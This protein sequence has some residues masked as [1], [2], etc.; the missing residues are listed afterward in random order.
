MGCARSL[1][2]LALPTL[3]LLAILA[4][5][6]CAA[7]VT[8]GTILGTVTDPSGA[9]LPGVV[10]KITNLDQGQERQTKTNELGDYLF[11]SL[12]L[13]S[14]RLSAEAKAFQTSVREGLQLHV[15]D[16]IRIDISMSVGNM[17]EKVT[18]TE[19]A[20]L[21]RSEDATQAH[22]INN[23]SILEMPLNNRNFAALALTAPGVH[24]GVTG[25]TLG[26][27]LG[28]GVSIW[29]NGQREFNNA[30]NL[31]GANMNIGFYSWNSFNP[32]VDAVQEFTI[33]S[34]L[35]SAEFGFQSG[36]NI[37][38]A[39][40]SGSNQLHGTLYDFLQNDD[41]N[42]RNFF[43]T[44][45]PKLRQ[46]QF[47]GTVGGPVYLPKLYNGR[48]RT[49]FFFNYEGVRTRQSAIQ[50]QT[51]P[52]SAQRG[53]DLSQTQ[54]G[55]AFTG[56]ILDPLNKQP[57]PN[58]RIPASRISSQAPKIL[59][60]Y[61]M[62]NT[63]G[64]PSYNFYALGPQPSRTTEAIVRMD[65]QFGARDSLFGHY[66]QNSIWRPA[67]EYIPSFSTLTELTAHNVA[68]NYMHIF[69]PTTL[70][71]FQTSF[72]RSWVAQTDPR[73]NTSFTA[74]QALGISGIP[75]SGTTA[76]FPN[77]AIQNYTSVGDPTNSPLLQPDQVLQFTDN[78]TLERGR[79]HLKLGMD[80][81][82]VHSER[83]QGINVR[84]AFSFLNT[85]A[86][87][88]GNSFADFL[89]GLPAQSSIGIAPGQERLRNQRYAGYFMDDWK[90]TPRLTLNLGL[91]YE[92][93][94]V[95]HDTRGTV[96]TF[97]L[98]SGKLIPFQPGQGM[99]GPAHNDW[100]PRIGFAYRPFGGNKTVVRGGYGIFYNV[101]LSGVL[102][103][104][105]SNPPFATQA[106]YFANVGA[107]A[108]S[109]DNPYPSAAQG[110]PSATPNVYTL[111]PNMAPARVQSLSL[112]I[113][114]QI[115]QSTVLDLNSTVTRSFGLDRLGMPNNA[116]PGPG[117]VQPR[118]PYPNFGQDIETRFDGRAWY[119][120]LTAKVE[121]RFSHGL[122]LTSSYTFSRNIDQCFSG[123]AGQP[124]DQTY[125]QNPYALKLEK[126]LSGADHKNRWISSLIYD[127]PFGPG[128]KLLGTGTA[129]KLVGGWQFSG[130][131]TA[132]SGDVRGVGVPGDWANVGSTTANT[133]PNRNCDGN[134][135]SDQRS[136]ARW[137]D[138]SCIVLPAQ[139]S[140]GNAGRAFLIG[141]ALF[142]LDL[143][144]MK[145]F[146]FDEKR[147]LQFRA[148]AFNA[149]N[150]TNL[151]TPG[152]SVGSPTYGVIT[153]AAPARTMQL[154]LKFVY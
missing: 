89:L 13:G 127:L 140:F 114:Q 144:L 65:Q 70:N 153:S 77:F 19:A 47:G 96:A 32:S 62:P 14:Y 10:M 117:A 38:I 130:F 78:V 120:G 152:G 63:T 106:T 72:N 43:A 73:T 141:P 52:T 102:F 105:E 44:T 82:H 113:Q 28:N 48:D 81:W 58:A 86:V 35:Y 55:T 111:S 109:F 4:P 2:K 138:T 12:P 39:I 93:V 101:P 124:N 51:M 79:H 80:F 129:G 31:D 122:A 119:Y 85:N 64:S 11:S 100:A 68:I 33:Q 16:K 40:R 8:T 84:G 18:V 115:A 90:V 88:S 150:H 61:P 46:N 103:N 83:W 143:G 57:F 104:V 15:Q 112:G 5:Q 36:G 67:A 121:R 91:R 69:S 133:R 3:L 118:R 131:Y 151:Y 147:R 56:T 92:L 125:P 49:F 45:I 26:T 149:A 123:V 94:T 23:K 7:Q 87:G 95:V 139:Y 134:L 142:S 108:I 25:A 74:Q 148:E 1:L 116:Q 146:V 137:F 154:G 42:G 128:Q 41:L 132:Q 60:Y 66:A 30:W 34:A 21:V 97:D 76:G 54:F 59:A 110:A 27:F 22:V 37:N 71:D 9:V 99:Y 107:P 24:P 98:A 75:A 126:G 53:G 29:A 135:P 145:N 20:P 17:T 6:P 50:L 136:I